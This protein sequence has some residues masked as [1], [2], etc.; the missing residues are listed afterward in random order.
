LSALCRKYKAPEKYIST[1]LGDNKGQFP[2]GRKGPP[3]KAAKQRVVDDILAAYAASQEGTPYIWD[4]QKGQEDQAATEDKNK[5]YSRTAQWV[6]RAKKKWE[7]DSS[8]EM[9]D[10]LLRE[11]QKRLEQMAEHWQ[12]SQVM[13]NITSF[14]TEVK[15]A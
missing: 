3:R 14:L 5:L 10:H 8:K 2:D 11:G 1:L 7:R 9:R 15:A 6:R 4:A 12:S 13:T